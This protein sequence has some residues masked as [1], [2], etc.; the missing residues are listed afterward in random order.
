MPGETDT[1]TGGMT[2]TVAVLDFVGS[3]TD[4]AVTET[5]AGFGTV[6]GAEYSPLDD[7]VPQP[8][9]EQPLPVTLQVTAASGVSETVAVNCCWALTRTWAVAGE[10]DTETG[11]MTVTVAV[12]DF[13]ESAT[14]VAV[15]ET[16]AG[17]GT[18]VGAV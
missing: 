12:L 17:V 3:A 14:E 2:V 5:R 15:I 11:G 16:C 10:I 9:P 18:F 7:M 13:V 4:L 1:E 6:D 8:A